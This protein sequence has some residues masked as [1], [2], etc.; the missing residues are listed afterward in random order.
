M[1]RVILAVSLI[2]TLAMTQLAQATPVTSTYLDE[3]KNWAGWT[4][5]TNDN[6]DPW[7][8][9]DIKSTSVTMDMGRLTNISFN[10]NSHNFG[11]TSGDLFIDTGANQSWDY[12]VRSLGATLNGSA[13]FALYQFSTPIGIHAANTYAMSHNGGAPASTYRSELPIGLLTTQGGALLPQTV[14]YTA[15]ASKISFDFGALSPLFFDRDFIIGYAVS[16]ANDVIYQQ[17]PVPEPGT[18]VLLGAG[19]LGLVVY[20]KR[21]MGKSS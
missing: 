19:L 17:V 14:D 10:L 3:A 7:G 5:L 12:V 13:T 11:V 20:S 6:I 18:M 21:R 15:D 1:K 8:T 4:A 2:V 9:P 16:C